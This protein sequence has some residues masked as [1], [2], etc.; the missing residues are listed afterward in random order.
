[1][2]LKKAQQYKKYR[3]VTICNK[4]VKMV[5]NL[6][7]CIRGVYSQIQVISEVKKYFVFL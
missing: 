5:Y 2:Q 1:M 4:L 7:S 3:S 6:F